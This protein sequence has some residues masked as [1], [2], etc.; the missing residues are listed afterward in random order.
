MTRRIPVLSPGVALFLLLLGW[1][2]LTMSGHTYTSDEETMLAAGESL[3]QHGTFALEPDFLM[4]LERGVDGQTYSRYGPGQS[5]AAVPFIVA[6]RLVASLAPD[7]ASRYI[8]R[9]FVLLLPALVTAAT[10]LVLYAWARQIGYRVRVALLVGLLYG[11]SMAWPYSRTFFAEPMATF[12]L[13]VCAYGMRRTERHWWAIAG[14]AAACALAVKFQS[15]LMLPLIGGYALLVCFCPGGVCPMC[16]RTGALVGRVTTGLAGMLVPLALLIFY[17]MR[18]FGGPFTTG[19]GTANPTSF[20]DGNLQE[21]VYGLLFST[22]KGLL[23]YSPTVL[24]GLVG[25]GMRWRQQW[26][27]SLLALA[28]LAAN[29]LFYGSIVYW[30]G[31]GSW[32]PRYMVFVLP[33]LLLPAAGV[34]ATV[35]ER[36]SRLA[37]AVIGVL[38]AATFLVQLL[39]VLVNF[40]TYILI[41]DEHQRHV[42]PSAS[43]IVGHTR[44]WLDRASEWSL[45]IA[46][47]AGTAVLRNGFSYSE[48]DRTQ[49]EVLPRWTYADATISL[50]PFASAPLDGRIVVGDHRPWPLERANF[51]LLLDGTPLEG[52]QRTDLT[53]QNI[54]WEL[55]FH[56]SA[57]QAR[58][59]AQLVLHSDT[60]NPNQATTDNPREE[61]LG[62]MLQTLELHQDEQQLALREALPIPTVKRG[63]RELWL[64][65]YDTP[66]HHLF[67]AWLWYVWVAALP[68][69]IVALLLLLLALPSLL[70]LLVGARG[71]SAALRS[72]EERR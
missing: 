38:A 51:L 57:E 29:L 59:G 37:T 62:L 21:G 13:V 12:F 41:S 3:V 32:G 43:P 30:H 54:M 15:L 24:L 71:V 2:V 65:F 39:P 67:D 42:T 31:D 64:W 10:G 44:I 17:N 28:V 5:L 55:R 61:D 19:Y 70:A 23:I 56:L 20:L 35:A 7:Y 68:P 6:G 36:R 69:P 49:G 50:Y 34:L 18:I 4:T 14:A 9:L 16:E 40:N 66:R 63:R 45:R 58:R 8:E 48:G 60:W 53:G 11:F 47:P 72:R 22:G 27:E 1:Y 25:L 52:V 46:P 26:R 33:F